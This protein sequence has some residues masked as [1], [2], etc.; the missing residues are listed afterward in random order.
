M[1]AKYPLSTYVKYAFH[2]WYNYGGLILFGGL[3]LIFREPGWWLMGA[4]LELGYLYY[5]STNVRFHRAIDAILEDR[6]HLEVTA[7]RNALWPY[8]HDDLRQRYSELEALA[9]RMRTEPPMPAGYDS[10]MFK[11]NQRKVATLLGSYLKIAVAVT[12]YR[13]YQ[14]SVN[15]DAVKGDITRL[16]GEL[17]TAG[18]RVREI[19]QKNIEILQKRLE[20][21]EKA[22]AN[23]EYL[24]AQMKAIEDTMRLVVDQ[25][26]TL[27]DPKGTGMQID[28]LLNTLQD[29]DLIAS[30][31]ENFEELEQGMI[32]DVVGLPQR[33]KK[34]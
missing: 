10:D 30:E 34:P 14:A 26:V 20:K 8:I 4:G 25:T 18:E 3:G 22:Q 27:S 31:M 12:R 21:I 7:L 2:N 9:A 1:E 32:D 28:N 15:A 6:K 24:V 29:A 19:K 23:C 16:Q 17:A 13:N 33:D 11:E 5:L